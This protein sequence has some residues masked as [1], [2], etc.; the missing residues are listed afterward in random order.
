MFIYIQILHNAIFLTQAQR[1]VIKNCTVTLKSLQFDYSA[2][3]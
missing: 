2:Y 3:Y 1:L